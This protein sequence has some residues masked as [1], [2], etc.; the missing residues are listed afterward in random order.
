MKIKSIFTL[1]MIL[2]ATNSYAKVV[3]IDNAY[4]TLDRFMNSIGKP[5][6]KFILNTQISKSTISRAPSKEAPAYHIFSA[7]DNMGFI[8]ISGDDIAKP[9]LG[10]SFN[11]KVCNDSMLPPAMEEWLQNIENQIQ[12]ARRNGITQSEEVAEMWNNPSI[13]GTATVKLK[14]AEWNQDSPYNQECPTQYGVKCLTGCV[15]TA[16]AILMKYYGYPASGKGTT[17]YYYTENG[18]YVPSRNLEHTYEWDLMPMLIDEYTTQE[19]IDEIARLMADIGA[20]IKAD[21]SQYATAAPLGEISLF[22][23]FSYYPGTAKAK[24][25]Y[26]TE[27][28]YRILRTELDNERPIIYSGGGIESDRH[29]FIIDGYTDDDYF[30]INWGWGGYCNGAYTLDALISDYSY[31]QW[32]Y[33]NTV[34]MS[35]MPTVA[36]LN[37]EISCPSIE[38]ALQMIPNDGTPAKIKM[39]QD[40]QLEYL[41]I[42]EEKNVLLDLNGFTINC[43]ES[44]FNDGILCIDDS[45]GGGKIIGNET[46][47]FNYGSLVMEQGELCNTKEPQGTN[48][49]SIISVSG[50]NTVI[51]G[52]IYSSCAY[53]DGDVTIEDGDFVG[54]DIYA[55]YNS[56]GNLT[57]NG[58]TFTNN[59]QHATICIE[60]EANIKCGTF[61][62]TGT[63]MT[64]A[65]NG[66][67]TIE[68]GLFYGNKTLY[69]YYG[70]TISCSGG[71][72]SQKVDEK[73]I[74]K[75]CH[76]TNNGDVSTY[77]RYPYRVVNR[78]TGIENIQADSN[79]TYY[80]LNG[81]K[82]GVR[83][84]GVYIVRKSDGKT[85]KIIER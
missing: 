78:T 74:D 32:A 79:E 76:C 1:I 49:K 28:W 21:Y 2:F 61:E 45:K 5:N 3:S 6:K 26:A 64:I 71:A 47:I 42:G 58:G 67:V 51:N 39:M 52:G 80:D 60:G 46:A 59:S 30:Y 73:F 40:L 68:D 41:S 83:Q 4:K 77:A 43:T 69:T 85:K 48:A 66:D 75:D 50:S 14:T 9:V 44:L 38:I 62:N 31:E 29:A 24:D 15:P 12:Y 55:I 37:D 19:E 23:H 84:T 20:A 63:G 34:P 53:L 11:H 27:D 17:P 16:Y 36:I 81:I 22:T 72:F 8:I 82:N 25:E 10:Y 65:S 7:E 56:S 35:H 54:R 13:K 18:N 70:A 33:I 57:I